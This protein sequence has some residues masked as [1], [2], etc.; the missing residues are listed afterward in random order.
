MHHTRLVAGKVDPKNKALQVLY[1]PRYM[2]GP[3]GLEEEDA[4]RKLGINDLVRVTEG[5]GVRRASVVVRRASSGEGFE[6]LSHVKQL[7]AEMAGEGRLLRVIHL[8]QKSFGVVAR[9]ESR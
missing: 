2:V 8:R 1:A 9:T 5:V 7:V 3:P 4:R 6:V